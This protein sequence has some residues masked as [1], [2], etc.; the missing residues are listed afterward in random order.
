MIEDLHWMD[1]ASLMLL[2][3]VLDNIQSIEKL[4]LLLTHRP[5]DEEEED[6]EDLAHVAPLMRH[7][8]DHIDE[9]DHLEK[10]KNAVKFVIQKAASLNTVHKISLK[11]LSRQ[12]CDT[13]CM[14]V[15][16]G[17]RA[18]EQVL[19]LVFSTTQGV[20][21]H[22]TLL[23]QWLE[24]RG[25]VK[26][27]PNK[28]LCRVDTSTPIPLNLHE[29][30]LKRLSDAVDADVLKILRLAVIGGEEFD[31]KFIAH[32]SG[33]SELAGVQDHGCVTGAISE[34]DVLKLLRKARMHGFV[35]HVQ[36]KA[37]LESQHRWRFKHDTIYSA[38]R[39][40]WRQDH[41]ATNASL[42]KT[43]RQALFLRLQA[44]FYGPPED[45][46]VV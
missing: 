24:E 2:S 32:V 6:I 31:A 19:G 11:G 27:S 30:I 20:P 29:T 45:F 41:L 23:M 5:I 42:L 15:V 4:A 44:G 28:G 38:M 26:T 33:I 16:G 9:E 22:A 17:A 36:D 12:D 14:R 34:R 8:S 1:Y 43:E 10:R 13:L 21:M 18:E 46:A 39:T 25:I 37:E 35:Q 3:Y 7:A 40:V